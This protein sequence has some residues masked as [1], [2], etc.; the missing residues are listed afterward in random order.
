M[1]LFCWAVCA[2]NPD[3]FDFFFVHEHFTR[4]L[5]TEHG[6]YEPWFFVP[7]LLGACALTDALG[8]PFSRAGTGRGS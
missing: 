7:I 8:R 3:F 2:A 5:T 4:Y 6:R 1:L